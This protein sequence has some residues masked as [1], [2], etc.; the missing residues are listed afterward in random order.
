[1]KVVYFNDG[2]GKVTVKSQVKG[3]L[4]WRYEYFPDGPKVIKTGSDSR[5]RTHSLGSPKDLGFDH[6]SFQFHLINVTDRDQDFEVSVRW[7]QDGNTLAQWV[8]KATLA[9]ANPALS[10]GHKLDLEAK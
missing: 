6:N 8:Q 5:P 1:M 4:K 3:R 7:L 2:G 9:V 10:I